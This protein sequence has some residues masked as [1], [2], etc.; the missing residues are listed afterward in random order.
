M[1]FS[2]NTTFVATSTSESESH[3]TGLSSIKPRDFDTNAHQ[4]DTLGDDGSR[5]ITSRGAAFLP[6][7]AAIAILDLGAGASITEVASITFPII[8]SSVS[9]SFDGAID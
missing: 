2:T 6:S 3:V 9:T 1:Y 5:A 4:S 7:L 8:N